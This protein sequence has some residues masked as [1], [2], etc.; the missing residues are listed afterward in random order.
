M[1]PL[2]QADQDLLAKRLREM[3]LS[4]L[5]EIS[6][7]EALEGFAPP[8]AGHEVHANADDAEAQ[9]QTEVHLGELQIDLAGLQDIEHAL[10]RM[11]EGG[12]GI[13]LDCGESI[14]RAR[15]LALPAAVRCAACQTAAEKLPRA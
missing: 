10:R 3:R 8:A 14:Q 6:A 4:A 9:R 2:T 13:C 15:L 1:T 5:N 12:Y 11:A 7:A